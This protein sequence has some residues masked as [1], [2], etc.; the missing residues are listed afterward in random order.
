[1]PLYQL[2]EDLWVFPDP[3]AADEHG[4][5]AIGGALEPA[6]LLLAYARGIFPWNGPDE[7]LQWWSP[8]PRM[9]L[10]LPGDLHV[11]RSLA[12]T[13]RRRGWRVTLDEDFAAV[14]AACA[15]PRA[16]QEGTWITPGIAA[17]FA[18]LH[19]RGAAHSVEVRDGDE[20]VG[21][22]Y[23]LAIGGAFCG[24]SMFSRAPDAS[25]L[26]LVALT[27][28][29]AA[30]GFALVDCQVASA[31][32]ERLGGRSLPREAFLAALAEATRRPG[33]LGRWRFD[34]GAAWT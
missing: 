33:R 24:E 22:L 34:P 20:L 17:A 29:L 26:G 6:R 8:A 16:G 1:M 11:P 7:P 15:A 18:D 5:L 28:Q 25:K 14:L 30:W 3:R 10:R 12:K 9:V 21:G 4:L 13:R 31:H 23:G 19:A 27:R 32:L 2:P